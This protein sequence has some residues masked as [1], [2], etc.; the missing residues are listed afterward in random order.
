MTN[1]KPVK[2]IEANKRRIFP[3]WK[4]INSYRELMWTLTY[5]DFRVKYAQT[6]LGF[7]WA[8]LNPLFTLVILSFIFGTVAKVDTGDVPHIIYTIAGLCGWTYFASVLSTA[9]QSLISSQN[10]IKK[11]YFP[12]LVIPFSKAIT[13]LIDLAIVFLIMAIL[14]LIYKFK[15]SA[16]LIYLPI[17]VIMALLAG[18]AAGIWASA[19]TIRYRDFKQIIPVTL[20]LGMYITPIA[21]PASAVP[22]KFKILFFLNPMAGVVEGMRWSLIG[23]PLPQL[24]LYISFSIVIILFFT[25]LIYFTKIEKVMVDII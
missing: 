18:L 12:R 22:E 15:P 11:I 20:R 25:G 16:N 19:L 13:G 2:I 5:R 1:T 4:E 6:A 10:M 8:I 14:M 17:F 7:L 23:G 3:N 9:G 21:F 24:E